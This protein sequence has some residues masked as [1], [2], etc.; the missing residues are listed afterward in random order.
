M[1]DSAHSMDFS[2]LTL[3]GKAVFLA[4]FPMIRALVTH[5]YSQILFGGR[6]EGGAG[7]LDVNIL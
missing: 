3:A 1:R 7:Q 6:C 5:R 2:L 4:T